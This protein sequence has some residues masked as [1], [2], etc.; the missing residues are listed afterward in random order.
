MLLGSNTQDESNVL[1]ENLLGTPD[2]SCGLV[3]VLGNPTVAGKCVRDILTYGL[4][5]MGSYGPVSVQGEY[6]GSQ[7][8]VRS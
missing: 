3:G 5:A 6:F 1:K 2:L 7:T 4:E 8:L